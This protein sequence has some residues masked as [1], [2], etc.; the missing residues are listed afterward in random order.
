MQARSIFEIESGD[1]QGATIF[2]S[3][4]VLTDQNEKMDVV[5]KLSVNHNNGFIYLGA[6]HTHE[7]KYTGS[8][9]TLKQLFTQLKK[10]ERVGNFVHTNFYNLYINKSS[11]TPPSTSRFSRWL[12]KVL[13]S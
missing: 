4:I 11:A 7:D 12:Q 8:S 6:N 10:Q 13:G 9:I 5:I 3:F 2:K 1:E